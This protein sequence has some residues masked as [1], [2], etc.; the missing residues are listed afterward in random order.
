MLPVALFKLQY[1][2]WLSHNHL[3]A[4]AVGID[5]DVDALLQ[6]ITAHALDAVNAHGERRAQNLTLHNA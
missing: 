2:T 6:F 4:G 1:T 3:A 5:D